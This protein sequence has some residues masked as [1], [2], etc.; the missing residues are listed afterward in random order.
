MTTADT[1]EDVAHF[2]VTEETKWQQVT[3]VSSKSSAVKRNNKKAELTM[4]MDT[5]RPLKIRLAK[6]TT[7]L[8]E[9]HV[10]PSSSE[11]MNSKP[12]SFNKFIRSNVGEFDS[13]ITVNVFSKA[14]ILII[15]NLMKISPQVTYA[16]DG[17][18]LDPIFPKD[19]QN[20]TLD[21]IFWKQ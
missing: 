7:A 2:F 5:L 8:Y 17:V 10:S 15:A 12:L 6:K 3:L 18:Y 13:V 20:K 14:P 11:K 21:I 19:Y 4:Q 9:I 1:Y 16:F